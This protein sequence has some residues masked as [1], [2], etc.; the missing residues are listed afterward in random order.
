MV[1]HSNAA[2]EGEGI[3]EY[4]LL[5]KARPV[6]ECST[7]LVGVVTPPGWMQG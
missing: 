1:E 5:V 6:I 7:V 3:P 4:A 2:P